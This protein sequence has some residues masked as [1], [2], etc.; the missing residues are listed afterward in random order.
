MCQT[1]ICPSLNP[2][3]NFFPKAFHVNE[4]QKAGFY[5]VSFPFFSR[6]KVAIGFVVTDIKSQTLIPVSVAAA[7]H[8]NFG[9]NE[10]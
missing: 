10:I 1:L 9:L 4:V 2:A 3:N 8:Y 5:L 7:T 6:V